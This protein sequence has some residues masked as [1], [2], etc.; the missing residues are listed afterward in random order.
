MNELERRTYLDAVKKWGRAS[1]VL[2]AVEEMA[3]LTKALMKFLNRDNESSE[4]RREVEE[5]IAD[6]LIMLDQL[7]IIF[8]E[9]SV[10]KQRFE[11]F[12]R[13]RLLL[14]EKPVCFNSAG[15]K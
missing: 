6:V 7:T 9:R 15:R 10:H 8:D 4:A 1:Q 2:M 12:E 13:L 3:E 14:N 5:E 11:K